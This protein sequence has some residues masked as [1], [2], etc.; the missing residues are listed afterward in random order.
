M[1][2]FTKVAILLTFIPLSDYLARLTQIAAADF[3]S[4]ITL[5]VYNLAQVSPRTLARSIQQ[6]RRIFLEAGIGIKW[7]ECGAELNPI[8]ACQQS[9][10][11]TPYMSGFGYHRSKRAWKREPPT[12]GHSM[13]CLRPAPLP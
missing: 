7:L 1:K 2:T 13:T 6:A 10:S 4:S 11:P 8:P 3:A 5:S 12:P 9:S